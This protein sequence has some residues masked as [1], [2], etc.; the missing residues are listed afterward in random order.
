MKVLHIVSPQPPG[1]TGGVDLHVADLAAAQL[2]GGP[3]QAHVLEL[4]DKGYAEALVGRGVP[5]TTIANPYRASVISEV[6]DAIRQ[7]SAGIVH[8]HGYDADLLGIAG[9]LRCPRPRPALVATVHGLIWTPARN[10]VK[11]TAT[12]AA[13][14]LVADAV[15]VTSR[16]RAARLRRVF[17][18]DRLQVIANGVQIV[19]TPHWRT[20]AQQPVMGYVGRLSLEKGVHRVIEVCASLIGR[21]PGLTCRIVG[22]GPEEEWLRDLADRLGVTSRMQFVGLSMDIAIELSR[23][24]VLLLLSDTE[25]TPRAV[26]EAMAA[27]VPVVAARIGG[28]PDLVQDRIDALLVAPGDVAAAAAAVECVLENPAL[29]ERLVA[30]AFR[31][32]QSEFTVE[33]MRDGVLA[34]YEEV[35]RRPLLASGHE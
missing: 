27:R 35:I 11:T 17:P 29:A 32:Y 7:V 23:I 34:V 30:S 10:F 21:L 24:D 22:T 19:P 4:G 13:L 26:V 15:I 16:Q 12:L 25:G 6:S 3:T 2:A 33:R 14:R 9:W 28:V 18:E 1:E 8:T 5:A 20:S 31:R